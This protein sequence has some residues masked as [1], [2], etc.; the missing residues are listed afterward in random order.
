MITLSDDKVKSILS[1]PGNNKCLECESTSVEWVSFPITIF[2][3]TSCSRK[4]SKF[5]KKEIL[6]SLSI[7]EFTEKE[8]S[9]LT[10]GGNSRFLSILSE[11][12]IPLLEPNLENK[13]LTFASAYYSALLEAE[14]N[15][16]N[17]VSG[18][19]EALNKLISQ[20]P[21]KELGPQLMGDSPNIY[22]EL[23]NSVK[24]NNEMGF[25]GF[26]G[27]IG[28]QIYNAAE[29]LG[30]NKVYNDTKNVVDTKMNEY[31]IKDTISKGVEYAK[32]AGGYIVDK[33]KEIA[34]TQMVQGAVNKVKEG[35]NYVNDTA[36]NMLNNISGTNTNNNG[37]ENN[38]QQNNLDFLN[39][40]NNQSVYQQLSHDQM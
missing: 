2:L 40:N 16:N 23:I 29:Q 24:S 4:H 9:K 3:C 10:I 37:I 20:K 33:S 22:M 5:T 6:K 32:S 1:L 17:N 35:V 31:G 12:N 19:E 28:N 34:S 7:E 38:N 18:A 8:V 25:G 15:K 21:N 11:Y 14:I 30:I 27:F 13:Y 36:T 39:N 26:F